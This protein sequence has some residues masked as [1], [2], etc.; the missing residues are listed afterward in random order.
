MKKETY[1]MLIGTYIPICVCFSSALL[2]AVYILCDVSI[3]AGFIVGLVAVAV[4]TVYFRTWYVHG[5]EK[6][7]SLTILAR[8]IIVVWIVTAI[9]S[10]VFFLIR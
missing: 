3:A 5:S 4:V 9:I 2:N 6:A 1:M 8:I 10:G 7:S